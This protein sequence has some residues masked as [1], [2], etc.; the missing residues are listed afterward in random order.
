M[1]RKTKLHTTFSPGSTSF[2]TLLPLPSCLE[3]CRGM[4]GSG[5]LV[6]LLSAVPPCSSVGPLHRPQFLSGDPV[7]AW[8]LHRLQFLQAPPALTWSCLQAAG[9]FLLVPQSLPQGAGKYLLHSG[10]F[11]TLHGLRGNFCSREISPS[12]TGAPLCLSSFS[13]LVFTGLFLTPFVPFSSAV[14]AFFSFS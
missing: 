11:Q 6:K 1:K 5:Q 12:V 13:T 9:R 10:L 3:W 14:L 7:P 8:A 2:P 4:A